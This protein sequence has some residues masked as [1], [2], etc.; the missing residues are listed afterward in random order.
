MGTYVGSYPVAIKLIE[1]F[2]H[3]N[4]ARIDRSAALQFGYQFCALYLRFSLRTFETVP[5]A[6]AL[7]R[8]RIMMVQ[9]G[10]KMARRTLADMTSHDYFPFLARL[11]SQA[12]LRVKPA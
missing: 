6:P 4:F 2:Q 12:R 10:R 5:T 11:I 1:K 7:S 3:S 9:D 8:H